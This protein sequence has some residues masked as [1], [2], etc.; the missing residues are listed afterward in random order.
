MKKNVFNIWLL[1]AVICGLSLGVTSCKDDDNDNG[2]GD[3]GQETYEGLS[4]LEDD[5]LADLITAW[6]DT[7]RDNLDG[8][9]WRNGTYEPTVGLALD[10]SQP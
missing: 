10:E 7:D 6:T 3:E 2:T 5:Q 9:A 8:T 4:T 1:A